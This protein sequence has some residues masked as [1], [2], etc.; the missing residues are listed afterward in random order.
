M[1]FVPVLL[2]LLA[3]A[4]APRVRASAADSAAVVRNALSA[5]TLLADRGPARSRQPARPLAPAEAAQ[6]AA[7][8]RQ[9]LSQ[10]YDAAGRA[11]APLVANLP[12]HPEVVAERVRLAIARNDA[13]GAVRLAREER[14]AQRDSVLVAHELVYALERLRRPAEAADVVLEAWVADPEEAEWARS[15][16]LRLA[17]ADPR[18][19]RERARRALRARPER[20]DLV[21][22]GALLDARS[23]EAR[24]AIAALEAADR[25]D[26][27]APLRWDF[28]REL[29]L[30]ADPADSATALAALRSLA[31][32]AHFPAPVRMMAAQRTWDVETTRGHRDE[33][34]DA[35][36]RALRDVPASDW[37]VDF[38]AELARSLRESGR[39]AL[40]RELLPA[41]RP[42]PEPALALEAALTEL[43]DGPPERALPSLAALADGGPDGAWHYAEALFF[44][45]AA[46][47]ALARYQRIADE[48]RGPFRGAALERAYLI[49]DADSPASAA[50]LGRIAYDEWRGERAAAMLRTDSLFRALP[51]G[52]LWARTALMLS[53]QRDAAG[54]APGAL[55]PLRAV[56]DSLPDDR[57]APLARQRAGDLCLEHL[58]DPAAA[59][60]QYEACLVRYP[61]AWNAAEVRRAVERLRREPRP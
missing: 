21:R 43:R 20:P 41:G 54:D 5:A 13:A 38:L 34:A 17:A 2:G 39:T 32:D 14:A 24:G 10:R 49:E 52:P 18:G 61:R 7:A 60:V 4:P 47:S 48:P 29:L 1:N 56:A 36:G 12:H 55:A 45:G 58:H 57:L 16:L 11:L 15:S 50:V 46:D 6:L 40:V 8:R 26:G 31:A 30:A 51:R 37:P 22:A 59:L 9:R 28:A 42:E 33:A 44:T 53:A 35:L 19:V 27:G 25:P 3:L 23:G